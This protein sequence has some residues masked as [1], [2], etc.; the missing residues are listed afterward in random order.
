MAEW[1]YEA[2]IGES[3]A[4]LVADDRIVEA[5][6]ER[7]GL[8]LGTVAPARLT[9]GTQARATFADGTEVQLAAAPH[10]LTQGAA[11]MLRVTREAI[12]E[13]GR[14]KLPRARLTDEAPGPGADLLA[15][16]TASGHP[17]RILRAHEPDALEAA[18]WS[19]ILDEATGGDIAFPGGALRMSPTPAMTLFDVDGGGALEPLAVAAATAVAQ[20]I[21]RHGVGGSIGIDFPTL[22]GKAPRHAVALAIDAALPLPFERTAV[23]GFG[24]LQIVRARPRA[25]LPEMLRADPVGAAARAALRHLERTPPGAPRRHAL[26]AAVHARL[27]AN[28]EWLAELARRTGTVHELETR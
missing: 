14:L 21:V 26:P 6:V 7:P 22:A 4:A 10:G 11:I 12:P 17:V 20:A 8:R 18:G 19:E 9:D 5:I 28:H 25:S 3:R 15:R 27:R 13:T 23:N 16:I 2:G 1:L 24:F